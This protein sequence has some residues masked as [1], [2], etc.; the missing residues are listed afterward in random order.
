M[1]Q[2]LDEYIKHLY[3]FPVDQNK[4]LLVVIKFEIFSNED[5]VLMIHPI[6]QIENSK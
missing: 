4:Q 1:L 2:L 5:V 3:C 6:L